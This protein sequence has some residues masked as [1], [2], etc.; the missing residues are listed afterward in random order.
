MTTDPTH[1]SLEAIAAEKAFFESHDYA[2]IAGLADKLDLDSLAVL[3]R[4]AAHLAKRAIRQSALTDKLI[5][6]DDLPGATAS[7]AHAAALAQ[8]S[9]ALTARSAYIDAVLQRIDVEGMFES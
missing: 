3:D 6:D 4:L 9:H 5:E 8:I 1:E 7:A 2:R